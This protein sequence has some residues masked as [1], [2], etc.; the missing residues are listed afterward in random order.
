MK[1]RM[2]IA[3]LPVALTLAGANQASAKTVTQHGPSG[4]IGWSTSAPLCTKV[5]GSAAFAIDFSGPSSVTLAPN[6]YGT[7]TLICNMPGIMNG[8]SWPYINALAFTFSKATAGLGCPLTL[9]L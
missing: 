8:L 4:L 7:V 2:L 1:I 6:A 9:H 3:S 5:A